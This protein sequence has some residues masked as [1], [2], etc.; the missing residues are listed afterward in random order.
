MINQLSNDI[1]TLK[2]EIEGR[3][4]KND[5]FYLEQLNSIETAVKNDKSDVKKD[6]LETREEFE[7][8]LNA[9][10]Q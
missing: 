2:E 9:Q 4:D 6:I 10:S 5:K 8:I 7:K 1:G 3:L